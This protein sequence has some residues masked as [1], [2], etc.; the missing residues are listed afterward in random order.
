MAGFNIV[1][2][3][4]TESPE[5]SAVDL[6]KDAK[7]FVSANTDTSTGP[8][9]PWETPADG[10]TWTKRE[11]YPYQLFL[12]PAQ[13]QALNLVAKLTHSQSAQEFLVLLIERGLLDELSS[14]AQPEVGGIHA[15]EAAEA[16]AYLQ[17]W[18]DI[19]AGR[20]ARG[21]R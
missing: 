11:R 13:K 15:K 19:T 4:K 12:S 7:R 18:G 3:S 20:K 10:E 5:A 2:P 16:L 1:K 8:F 17:A 6:D 21:Q 9:P 14:Y